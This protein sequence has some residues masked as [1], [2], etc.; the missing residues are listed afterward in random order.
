M[1]QAPVHIP[2]VKNVYRDF[3]ILTMYT[4]ANYSISPFFQFGGFDYGDLLYHDLDYGHRLGIGR[5]GR[6]FGGRFGRGRG[7]RV[8]LT[9]FKNGLSKILCYYCQESKEL[10]RNLAKEC[11]PMT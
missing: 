8:R 9:S 5:V 2:S 4:M 10:S 7:G 3:S 11:L 6:G 1:C